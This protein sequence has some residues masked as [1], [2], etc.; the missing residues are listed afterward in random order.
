LGYLN[1]TNKTN[2][3]ASF[4]NR[5]GSV[6]FAIGQSVELVTHLIITLKT[7]FCN[8]IKFWMTKTTPNSISSNTL[9]LFY[10]KNS[11]PPTSATSTAFVR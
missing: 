11:P 7:M 9:S 1:M 10:K 6:A 8:L 3:I 4:I 5:L 2:K